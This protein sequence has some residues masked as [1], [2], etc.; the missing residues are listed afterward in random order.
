[1]LRADRHTRTTTPSTRAQELRRSEAGVSSSKRP[2]ILFAEP[3]ARLDNYGREEPSDSA[4]SRLRNA[5][6]AAAIPR[7]PRLL[8]RATTT[9]LIASLRQLDPPGVSEVDGSGQ[10]H[11]V[12]PGVEPARRSAGPSEGSRHYGRPL[13]RTRPPGRLRTFPFARHRDC[14]RQAVSERDAALLSSRGSRSSRPRS[15]DDRFHDLG[16]P[17]WTTPV[18]TRGSRRSA[19]GARS[20][21]RKL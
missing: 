13:A 4:A 9:H 5:R 7:R 15:A 3:T 2:A 6:S 8:S 11:R 20:D 16:D 18:A 12:R 1:M 19:R 17:R 21:S 14:L 10:F